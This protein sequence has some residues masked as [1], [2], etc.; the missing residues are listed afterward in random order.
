MV[1]GMLFLVTMAVS[2]TYCTSNLRCSELLALYFA[3]VLPSC[4]GT[5]LF[6]L[7][8]LSLVYVVVVLGSLVCFCFDN[9]N[10]KYSLFSVKVNNE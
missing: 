1:G 7:L 6:R 8:L 4:K 10:T 2:P 5:D 3:E 9:C